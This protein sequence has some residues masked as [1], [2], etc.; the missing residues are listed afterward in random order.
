MLRGIRFEDAIKSLV[1]L[2][3]FAAAMVAFGPGL[4]ER[5]GITLKLEAATHTDTSSEHQIALQIENDLP[6]VDVLGIKTLEDR[7]VMTVLDLGKGDWKEDDLTKLI[8]VTFYLVELARDEELPILTE[9][10]QESEAIT[11]DAKTVDIFFHK[12]SLACPWVV[13]EQYNGANASSLIGS[14][15]LLPGAYLEIDAKAISWAGRGE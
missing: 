12:E 13:I 4:L 14:C 11:V 6:K 5:Y 10:W 9:V 1:G 8:E 2:A 15:A 7:V 3:I